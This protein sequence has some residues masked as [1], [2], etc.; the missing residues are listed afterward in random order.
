MSALHRRRDFAV[1]LIPFEYELIRVDSCLFGSSVSWATKSGGRSATCWGS[2]AEIASEPTAAKQVTHSA[3]ASLRPAAAVRAGRSR[4]VALGNTGPGRPAAQPSDDAV[5]HLAII[6]ARHF[7]RLV[8]QRRIDHRLFKSR[9]SG[10]RVTTSARLRFMSVEC[11]WTRFPRPAHLGLAVS[12][13]SRFLRQG[14]ME[15]AA[16]QRSKD[17]DP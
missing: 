2:S 15:A 7:A 17:S 9:T 12:S 10:S 13:Q 14:Y 11:E 5:Q 6:H 4:A 3:D 16:C 1:S 8:G